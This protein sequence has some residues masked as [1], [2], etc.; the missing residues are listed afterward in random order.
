[1]V[2][3]R[4]SSPFET[5]VLALASYMAVLLIY[6][7]VPFVMLPTLGQ[8]VWSLGFAES[9]AKTSWFAIYGRHFGLPDP[10][11]IAFGLAGVWP[12][13]LLMRLGL[14][15]AEA[16]AAVMA[17]WLGVALSSAY[18]LA[19][20]FEVRPRQ[21]WLAALC[22]MSMP[23]IWA[24]A[25]YS[26]L[27]LGIALLPFYFLAAFR[28]FRYHQTLGHAWW[29]HGLTYIFACLIAVFMDGY[30]FVMFAFGAT[31]LLAGAT[32]TQKRYRAYVIKT[33]LPIHIFG[34]A[35]AYGLYSL[36]V[37]RTGFEAYPLDFFRGWSL[38]LSFVVLPT[39]GLHWLLDVLGFSQARS[40][41]VYFGDRSVWV[42]TFGLPLLLVAMWATWSNLQAQTKRSL[43]IVLLLIALC[44]FYLALGPTLK[45]NTT[46]PLY[47]QQDFAGQQ[48]SSMPPE[49]GLISTGTGWI[50][51]HVPAFNV[52]RATYRWSAL[53]FFFLWLLI[54]LWAAQRGHRPT[55]SVTV[56]LVGVILL[57]LP[58][59]PEKWKD[60]RADHMM[61]QQIDQDL[62]ASLIQALGSAERVAFVP[63]NN[64][65]LINYVAAAGGFRTLNIGGD[66]NLA[67]AQVSWP[68]E[69]KA[70]KQS[71]QANDALI[72]LK[73]LL[74][75]KVDALVVPYFNPLWSAFVWPCPQQPSVTLTSQTAARYTAI[76]G[77][78]C[79]EVYR[80]QHNEFV[81]AM[82]ELPWIESVESPWFVVLRLS[83]VMRQEPNRHAL[84]ARLADMAS[85]PILP[86]REDRLN[87][88]VFRRGWHEPETGH[89]W[90]S[91]R[92]QLSLPVP[93][94]CDD[95]R[96]T[97]QLQF[98]AFGASPERPVTVVLQTQMPD[99]L[100]RIERVV[101]DEQMLTMELPLVGTQTIRWQKILLEIA[102]A[103]SPS[104]LLGTPDDRVL[105]VSLRQIDLLRAQ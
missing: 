34:F 31:I 11:P 47:L 96:C 87:D 54:V 14:H 55:R 36:Y 38:D 32:L 63:W 2:S 90:S 7:A 97:V 70:L 78:V 61:F 98:H 48:S 15:A 16:Y 46:K 69:M 1:M 50:Y 101:S 49:Y 39:Q 79:P 82:L 103:T 93:Q 35:L 81:Q 85:Y 18:L 17:V 104:L 77:F 23:M 105:G 62:V 89:V 13:S 19:R 53:G 59:L 12:A 75:D 91:A 102:Q 45:I 68:P 65:F 41:L 72:A 100:W 30:T 60:A 28:L 76:D 83:P 21:A 57:N 43:S 51:E 20:Y 3:I 73:L 92:A 4:R 42:T 22:W 52:M 26:M 24:H 5:A 44:S 27:S 64:D 94:A 10:A 67:Q 71:V 29:R 66:K 33:A 84:L 80:E 6:S 8:A 56:I 58:N 37:G 25:D 99:E 9:F 95:G 86:G 88:Y 74:D 40:D